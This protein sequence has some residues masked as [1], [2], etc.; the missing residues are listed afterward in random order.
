MCSY[1]L[2]V[3]RG[4]RYCQTLSW[5]GARKKNL[6]NQQLLICFL[7]DPYVYT[8]SLWAQV[9]YYLGD[10]YH[11]TS[12]T[13]HLHTPH[14]LDK[15]ASPEWGWLCGS[16]CHYLLVF[17]GEREVFCELQLYFTIH[18]LNNLP[19]FSLSHLWKKRNRTKPKNNHIP[20]FNPAANMNAAFLYHLFLR[21]ENKFRL[22]AWS[23]ARWSW[24]QCLLAQNLVPLYSPA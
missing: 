18:N 15:M 16:P 11:L 8:D 13:P 1:E 3:L 17:V 6:T 21:W 14:A 20:R 9:R 22:S 10:Y 5:E 7:L 24:L 23:Q 2:W 4:Q 12:T 19:Q